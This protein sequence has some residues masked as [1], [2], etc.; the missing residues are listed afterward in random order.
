MGDDSIDIVY[1]ATPSSRHVADSL[2]CL[3]A[4]RA[5]LCEK[6]MA[7]SAEEAEREGKGKDKE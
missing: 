1:I 7:P 2:A 4:G 3:E 5:V 6:S